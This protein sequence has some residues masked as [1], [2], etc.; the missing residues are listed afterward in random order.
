[1]QVVKKNFKIIFFMIFYEHFVNLFMTKVHA[2]HTYMYIVIIIHVLVPTYI[3][4]FI[5]RGSRP[6]VI[7]LFPVTLCHVCC[8]LVYNTG[9]L[10]PPLNLTRLLPCHFQCLQP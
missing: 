1:M 7:S 10:D 6:Y 4:Y 5:T 2:I 3:D 9:E 8:V